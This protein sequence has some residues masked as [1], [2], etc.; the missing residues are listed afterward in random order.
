MKLTMTTALLQGMVAKAMKG[1]SCNRMK[2][3]RAHV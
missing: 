2:I 1:A 3:G